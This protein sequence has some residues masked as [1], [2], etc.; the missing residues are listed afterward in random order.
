R[1]L[2][3]RVAGVDAC[4]QRGE[5]GRQQA[6][7]IEVAID[8]TRGILLIDIEP[9]T[10]P[11]TGPQIQIHGGCVVSDH[12]GEARWQ[13]EDVDAAE[14]AGDAGRIENVAMRVAFEVAG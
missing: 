12:G 10:S 2:R 4:K 7:G 6:A 9:V 8:G 5:A 13:V 1:E 14:P 3:Q 11:E